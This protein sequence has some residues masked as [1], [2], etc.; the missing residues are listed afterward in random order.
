MAAMETS[1]PPSSAAIDG[2]VEAALRDVDARGAAVRSA[3]S[4]ALAAPPPLVS[5]G[6]SDLAAAH[7]LIQQEAQLNRYL[8]A[9]LQSTSLS[10][11]SPDMTTTT[12]DDLAVLVAALRQCS[13]NDTSEAGYD[14]HNDDD[15]VPSSRVTST[16]IQTDQL[17]IHAVQSLPDEFEAAAKERSR[18]VA[19]FKCPIAVLDAQK[20][21]SRSSVS[22]RRRVNA[23]GLPLEL[24]MLIGGVTQNLAALNRVEL[25]QSSREFQSIATL[26][27]SLHAAVATEPACEKR[28][29][30]F[31]IPADPTAD[32]GT[33]RFSA[34]LGSSD[35]PPASAV[36]ASWDLS[37][38][39]SLTDAYYRSATL[40]FHHPRKDEGPPR[41]QSSDGS[42]SD[43]ASVTR[44]HIVFRQVD[45]F[46]TFCKT[47]RAWLP[48]L[49]TCFAQ[50]VTFPAAAH[51]PLA[52]LQPDEVNLC[53]AWHVPP[54]AYVAIKQR[55]L[56]ASSPGVQ[57]PDDLVSATALCGGPTN[58]H[59][60]DHYRLWAVIRY[61]AKRGWIVT[62]T[63]F[64][65][66]RDRMT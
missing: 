64:R 13:L 36:G 39:R 1:L 56:S 50:S 19:D 49:I 17:S 43:D 20:G 60:L 6:D 38:P 61:F 23:P 52:Y 27:T 41:K 7:R 4:T 44:T 37:T 54:A 42:S 51:P 5:A 8:R 11:V 25:G 48:G 57:S 15:E 62:H 65:I 18:R 59:G 31:A 40:V 53:E 26:L 24:G 34:P 16:A 21:A 30:Q 33:L 35:A 55:L 9:V 29:R 22:L 10:A 28:I 2:L 66:P 12:G 46:N 32:G 3:L 63:L 45:Q 58:G 47:L 14:V